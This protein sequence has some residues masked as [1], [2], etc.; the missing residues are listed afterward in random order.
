VIDATGTF[1]ISLLSGHIGGANQLTLKISSL[2]KAKSVITTATDNLNIL[3]PDVLAKKFNLII[4]DKKLL[5]AISTNLVNNK[6]V[7]FYDEEK[8]INPG[9]GY[10]II[11]KSNLNFNMQNTLLIT[12][13]QNNGFKG[14]KLIRKN[15]ILGVGCRK[16]YKQKIMVDSVSKILKNLDFDWR[17]VKS[18]VSVEIKKNEKAII[19]LAKHFKAELN[20]FK[21]EEIKKIEKNFIGSEFVKNKIGVRAVAE[22]CVVLYKGNIIKPKIKIDGMTLAIGTI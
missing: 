8:K 4:D 13:R 10:F 20:F 9:K 1:F 14:L 6:P 5:K 17:S 19:N 3:A 16:N 18:I 11:E 2:L 12:N 22:P 15:L 21:I 7:Y